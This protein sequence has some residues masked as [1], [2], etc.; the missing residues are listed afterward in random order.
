MK[1]RYEKPKTI[2]VTVSATSII[3]SSTFYRHCNEDCRYWHTCRDRHIG[4]ICED[5]RYK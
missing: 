3:S 4:M 2:V 1:A 5:K